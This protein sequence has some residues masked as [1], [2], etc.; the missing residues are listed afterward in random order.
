MLKRSAV[1]ALAAS[2][3]LALSAPAALAQEHSHWHS[4]GWGPDKGHALERAK[5]WM[6]A[7]V[8]AWTWGHQWRYE[9][10]P[11]FKCKKGPEWHC[12][13]SADVEKG[14]RL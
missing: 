10:G 2:A 11:K 1:A 6:N 8:E 14:R 12:R 7:K 9:H 4:N 3:F 13:G 5:V